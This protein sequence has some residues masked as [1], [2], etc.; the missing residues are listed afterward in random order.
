M[1]TT[2]NI[3]DDVLSAARE[4]ASRERKP[5]GRVISESARR[6][7][8]SAPQDRPRVSSASNRLAPYG[9]QPLPSRGGLVSNELI[10]RLRNESDI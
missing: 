3:D 2:L 6:T 4:I 1:R 7:L 9:I 8:G 10:D 5:L